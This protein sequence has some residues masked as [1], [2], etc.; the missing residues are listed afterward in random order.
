MRLVDRG[1]LVLDVP[2]AA[3]APA[4]C[5][6]DRAG[7]TVRD[8]LLHQGGLPAWRPYF[9]RLHGRDAYVAAIAAEPLD[10]APRTASVY[11]DL[12]FILLGA[13]LEDLGGA[14]LDRQFD[15]FRAE[16]LG[17]VPL[18][19]GIAADWLPRVAPTER[20]PWRGRLL[21]GEVHDENAFALGGVAGHAGLFG[22]AAAVSAFARWLQPIWTGD[23]Q[24]DPGVSVPTAQAF[25]AEG[26]LGVSSRAH[27][28][29]T[30]RTTSSCGAHL[31]TTAVGHTGFTGTSLWIDR[32]RD[33][34]VV[35]LTN[36]VHPTRDSEGI[37][38]LRR[39]VHDAVAA[40]R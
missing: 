29:D 28:W 23:Q 31:S 27:G 26:P 1:R 33:L 20:D 39:A 18:R 25:L 15:A 16:S 5:G 17:D 35:L 3:L 11:S 36:R 30:M 24:H 10:Y 6:A 4:W 32:E 19:Y 7:V 2:I 8:L 40:G 34:Y 21:R 22:T 12:G 14:P 38:A 13:I 9:E 37:Q